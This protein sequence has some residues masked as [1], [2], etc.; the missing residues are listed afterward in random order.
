MVKRSLKRL[1]WRAAPDVFAYLMGPIEQEFAIGI[2]SGASPFSL[3]SLQQVVNPVLTRAHVTDVP[4]AFV[5]DPF[6]CRAGDRWYM[7][8]EVLN[9]FTHKG[10]IGLASSDDGAIWRYEKIVLAE[11][12]HVSYPYVFEWENDYYLVPEAWH[13]G[14]IRLYKSTN[15]PREWSF[16][17]K[18]I[19]DG[20]FLD[21]SIFRYQNRWWLFTA[22]PAENEALTLRLYSATAL[23]GE[24]EEHPDSPL[25][26][27]DNHIVRPAGRVLVEHGRPIRFAQDVFP[28][29][30]SRVHAFEVVELST[31]RYRERQIGTGP[32]LAAGDARWNNGGMHHIDAHALPGGAWIACVDG[33]PERLLS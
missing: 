13:D 21:S 4:A 1:L 19:P 32:V 26:K 6:M 23:L 30:G 7:F 24:W 20:V 10:E 8:F 12:F 18:L 28:V 15:F 11:P 16:V 17:G 31:S 5:A 29:Y 3:G 14:G 2:L 9:R 33:F 22:C 27:A 25:I